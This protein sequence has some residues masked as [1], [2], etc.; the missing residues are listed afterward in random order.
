MSVC[1]HFYTKKDKFDII[2][3]IVD[4]LPIIVMKCGFVFYHFEFESGLG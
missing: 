2:D 3:L 4:Y 1:V